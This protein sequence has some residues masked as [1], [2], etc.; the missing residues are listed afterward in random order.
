MITYHIP[1]MSCGHCKATVE[2]TIHGLDPVARIEFDM[3]AR[4]VA[5][6]SNADAAIVT[7]ALAKVGFPASPA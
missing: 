2:K 4:K 1:D 6:E 7:A 3:P 5:V